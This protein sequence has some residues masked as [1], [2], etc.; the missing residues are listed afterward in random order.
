M[1][2]IA[3][4]RQLAGAPGGIGG[5][6]RSRIKQR[7]MPTISFM[8]LGWLENLA[9]PVISNVISGVLL[10]RM[11]R[12]RKKPK[13]KKDRE[14]KIERSQIDRAR[15]KSDKRATDTA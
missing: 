2:D 10:A 9:N 13:K 14:I 7:D 11:L 1:A 15:R 6:F 4:P 12:H 5:Q 3:V 8:D